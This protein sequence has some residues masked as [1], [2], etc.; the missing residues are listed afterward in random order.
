LWRQFQF[1]TR[2]G[3]RY[4]GTESGGPGAGDYSGDH[5][6]GSRSGNFSV[7]IFPGCEVDSLGSGPRYYGH[8]L[9]FGLFH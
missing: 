7:D 3:A 4:L 2:H 5:L 1:Q 8:V 9:Q 6:V